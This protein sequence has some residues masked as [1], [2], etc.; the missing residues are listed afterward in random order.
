MLQGVG[1]FRRPLARPKG[2][3]CVPTGAVLPAGCSVVGA[4][5]VEN[6][7]II[8]SMA[9]PSPGKKIVQTN[10]VEVDDRGLVYVLDRF[11]GLDIV[12]FNGE[13]QRARCADSEKKMWRLIK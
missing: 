10:G 6:R 8:S 2:R 9:D 12:E 3:V 11:Q 1:D 4:G 7:S 13:Q 5:R